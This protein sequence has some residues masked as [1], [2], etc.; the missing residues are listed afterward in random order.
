LENR[1]ESLLSFIVSWEPKKAS[2]SLGFITGNTTCNLREE[3]P[4]SPVLLW[5]MPCADYHDQ[6]WMPLQLV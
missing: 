1:W 5:A 2:A 6:F 3:I 4:T